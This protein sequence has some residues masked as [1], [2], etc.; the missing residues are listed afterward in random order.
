MFLDAEFPRDISYGS[1]GGPK[2]STTVIPLASGRERRNQNW[3][4][5]RSEYD[6]SHGVKVADQMQDLREFFFAMRGRAHS[7]RYFDHADHLIEFQN[8][9]EGDGETKEFQLLKVYSPGLNPFV[10]PITKPIP[11]TL[12]GVTVNGIIREE[13]AAG[14]F[15]MDYD[16]GIFTFAEPIPEGHVLSVIRCEFHVHARFDTDLFD[17][18]H[19]FWQTESWQSIMIVEIKDEAL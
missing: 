7:F 18:V 17:S 12:N 13:G 16:T 11:G 19:D 1:Q 5:I 2:F 3:V 10:R 6:V 15:V 4:N 9:A 8:I 14:D